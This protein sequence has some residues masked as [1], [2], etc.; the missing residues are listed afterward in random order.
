MT[1][2]TFE[3]RDRMKFIPVLAVRL[4]VDNEQDG[5]LIR[6]AGFGLQSETYI[7]VCK[8][9]NMKSS[10]DPYS[11]GDNTMI[12]AHHHIMKHFDEL[13][14]GAVIDVEFLRGESE[15]PKRSERF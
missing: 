12:G 15:A 1:S 4:D 11:W 6:R 13:P 2:K 9:S 8:F 5:Y 3:I 14:T 7:M 10:Y